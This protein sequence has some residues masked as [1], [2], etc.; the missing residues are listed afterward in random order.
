MSV[1]SESECLR[2]RGD[3]PPP[4]PPL[5]SPRINAVAFC[6]RSTGGDLFEDIIAP[7]L[8]KARRLAE[9]AA[10]SAYIFIRRGNSA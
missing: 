8:N 7:T 3:P 1:N 6:R 9:A 10:A 5:V 4:P 2:V